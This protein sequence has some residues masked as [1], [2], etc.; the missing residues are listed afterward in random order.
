MVGLLGV[1]FLEDLCGKGGIFSNERGGSIAHGCRGVDGW[2][3][4]SRHALSMIN[5]EGVVT[6]GGMGLT[7]F[8][9]SG[10]LLGF[11]ALW[12]LLGGRWLKGVVV[13]VP[14]RQGQVP[15]GSH[16]VKVIVAAGAVR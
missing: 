12:L 11:L 16:G 2:V 4:V 3:G 5:T 7:M 13:Q 9:G 1:E 8:E 6:E 14:C 10:L 15:E